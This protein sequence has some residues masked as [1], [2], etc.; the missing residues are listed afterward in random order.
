MLK[1][2]V[3]IVVLSMLLASCAPVVRNPFA[4]DVPTAQTAI[5]KKLNTSAP[6]KVLSPP[7]VVRVESTPDG[8][9]ALFSYETENE[10]GERVTATG[11]YDLERRGLDGMRLAAA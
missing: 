8:A 11:V 1:R 5:E 7:M 3:F 6:N 2:F 9:V 4:I 10:S